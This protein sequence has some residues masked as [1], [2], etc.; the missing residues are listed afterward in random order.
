MSAVSILLPCLS[1]IFDIYLQDASG[2]VHIWL[3]V[4]HWLCNARL[5]S[6]VRKTSMLLALAKLAGEPI[7]CRWHDVCR[8][9]RTVKTPMRVPASGP[10]RSRGITGEVVA[11][12]L[13]GVLV[14]ADLLHSSGSIACNAYCALGITIRPEPCCLYS[15]ELSSTCTQL[16]AQ[17]LRVNNLGASLALTTCNK[18]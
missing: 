3:Q 8:D 12:G 9:M 4:L 5:P 17:V 2:R 18:D 15:G 14:E 13:R 10:A 16:I 7:S 11:I 6:R 1:T